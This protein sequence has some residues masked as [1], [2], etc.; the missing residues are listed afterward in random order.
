MSIRVIVLA[1]LIAAWPAVSAAQSH[2]L[3]ASLGRGCVGG[4]G[5]LC[6]NSEG[7]AVEA[8]V[9]LWAVR[10]VSVTLAVTRLSLNT[11]EF[12][13]VDRPGV[14]RY[15]GRSRQF[16]IALVEWA[17]RPAGVVRPVIGFGLGTY[18]ERFTRVCDPGPCSREDPV[19]PV[20]SQGWHP[21]VVV[22][23]GLSGPLVRR[24]SWQARAQ[25]HRPFNDEHGTWLL[26]GGVNWRFGS[27]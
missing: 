1:G 23:A 6:G 12:D 4:E 10:P 13:R 2:E 18:R 17:P 8:H 3:G 25:A 21:D 22:A 11:Q 15:T 19:T 27:R 24:L 14:V 26:L 7:S 9:R 5:S 16:L 20:V